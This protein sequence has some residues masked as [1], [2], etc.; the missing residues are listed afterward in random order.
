MTE[1][2]KNLMRQIFEQHGDQIMSDMLYDTYGEEAIEKLSE[3]INT[4][5]FSFAEADWFELTLHYHV[6]FLEKLF[7]KIETDLMIDCVKD[8]I[9]SEYNVNVSKG[10]KPILEVDPPDQRTGAD[11]HLNVIAYEA[12]QRLEYKRIDDK[13]RREIEDLIK[14]IYD[15]TLSIA[16]T[17]KP[18]SAHED[19]TKRKDILG[20]MA[21]AMYPIVLENDSLKDLIIKKE[22]EV[23]SVRAE[24]ADLYFRLNTDKGN[25][26]KGDGLTMKPISILF[27]AINL[28]LERWAVIKDCLTEEQKEKV[29]Y[30]GINKSQLSS[31]IERISGHSADKVR[32][33]GLSDKALTDAN[34]QIAINAIKDIIPVLEGAIRNL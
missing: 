21:R 30:A 28:E 16:D 27:R 15:K 7:E 25:S 13:Q 26:K 9:L 4:G 3:E 17:I 1:H 20:K 14:K 5:A 19:L 33:E 32:R 6:E 18:Q 11:N 23:T 12:H 34:K 10:M 22:R 2:E 29:K 24:Y 31:A 8:A